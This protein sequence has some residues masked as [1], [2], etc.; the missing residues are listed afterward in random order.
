[1]AQP[2]GLFGSRK[3]PPARP[4]SAW[5]PE[6]TP[7]PKTILCVVPRKL[8]ANPLKQLL[9]GCELTLAD[10]RTAMLRCARH[11]AHDLYVVYAPL[12]WGEAAEVCA[13]LRAIDPTTPLIVYSIQRSTAERREALAAGAQAYV[14]PSDDTHQL[15]GTAAQLIM[16]A[17]LRS[18][19]A[20]AAAAKAMQDNL[21][22]G[23]E[24]LPRN[25]QDADSTVKRVH[26]RLKRQTRRIFSSVGGTRA[27]FERVWL[28]IYDAALKRLTRSEG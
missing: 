26:D 11:E 5:V 28:S 16:L 3:S 10:S 22:S 13:R 17:E 25:T 23:L 24:R 12:S 15:A 14:T 27:N 9:K 2:R 21:V 19:E 18:V 6:R 4:A 7:S 1:M 20:L 8:R